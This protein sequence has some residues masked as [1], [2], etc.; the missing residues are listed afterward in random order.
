MKD[1]S[2]ER[3]MSLLNNVFF[4]ILISLNKKLNKISSLC[5]FLRDL[6]SG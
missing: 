5:I 1:G 6:N 3:M 4:A 2:E